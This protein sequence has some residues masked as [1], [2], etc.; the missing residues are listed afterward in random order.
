MYRKI[1]YHVLG[2]AALIWAANAAAENANVPPPNAVSNVSPGVTVVPLPPEGYDP[3]TAPA[4]MN[5]RYAVP[6]APDPVSKPKEHEAWLKAVHGK[7]SR[8]TPKLTLTNISNSSVRN[9]GERRPSTLGNAVV[10]TTSG[11]WSGSADE[12]GIANPNNQ[13]AVEA[14]FVVPTAHQA[15]GACTGGWDYSSVWPGIDGFNSNDV[16]Q[17][18]I[19]AD[20]YCSGGT[21]NTFYSAWV[22]WYPF[23]ETRVSS[24]AISPGDLLFVEVWNTTPTQGYVYFYDYSTNVAAEYSLTPPSGTSL[25]GNSVEWVVERPG[26]GGGLATLTNYIDVPLTWGIAWDYTASPVTYYY[27]YFNPSVGTL[28]LITMLDNNG[29]GISYG[30]GL[31]A[32]TLW[33]FDY[34]SACGIS[35][36]PC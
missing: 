3:T 27:P 29:N 22:E 31:S 32:E 11:N 30:A 1:P 2:A 25:Q 10:S 6:P 35:S 20:A 4:Q 15:V 36:P 5:A 7:P 28:Y 9:L 33:F 24:P 14:L 12:S 23:N 34:G 19:E 18:G 8:E 17:G 21:R 13:E 26:V 16:L